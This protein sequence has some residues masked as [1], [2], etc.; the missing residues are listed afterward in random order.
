MKNKKDIIFSIFIMI[1]AMILFLNL[2]YKNLNG[3]T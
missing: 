1:L 2:I 3:L